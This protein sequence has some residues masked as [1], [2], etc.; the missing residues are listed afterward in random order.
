MNDDSVPRAER[1]TGDRRGDIES[2]PQTAPATHF[3]GLVHI[4]PV[5]ESW[6][7]NRPARVVWVPG[8]A[9]PKSR[10]ED[11]WGPTAPCVGGTDAGYDRAVGSR[12]HRHVREVWKTQC[13]LPR[14]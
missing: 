13:G 6:V 5:S 8:A 1:E 12:I 4:Q 10:E 11:G 14:R 9:A 7:S 2:L 3:D